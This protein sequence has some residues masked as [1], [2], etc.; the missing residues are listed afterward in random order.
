[1]TIKD[2]AKETGYSVGTISRVLNNQPNV[3][4]KARD[5]ILAIVHERGF[6]LNTNAKTLKQQRSNCIA[7]VVKGTANEMFASLVE[8]LQALFAATEHPLIVDFIDEDANEVKRGAQADGP[9]VPR[10]DEHLL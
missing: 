9:D 8:Q 4:Q 10:R 5:A 6:Q 1:M 3:S 7:A 2:L